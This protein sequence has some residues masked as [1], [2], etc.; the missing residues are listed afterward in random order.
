MIKIII[1]FFIIFLLSFLPVLY[2]NSVLKFDPT[3]YANEWLRTVINSIILFFLLKY[4][5][6]YIDRQKIKNKNLG[7]LEYYKQILERIKYEIMNFNSSESN[8]DLCLILWT[9]FLNLKS[10]YLEIEKS[11]LKKN[12]KIEFNLLIYNI[13]K[14]EKFNNILKGFKNNTLTPSEIEE[15]LVILNSII[16]EIDKL[17]NKL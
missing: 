7:F 13:D 11:I 16:S 1:S 17:K 4:L 15:A 6:S 3:V 12:H 9:K 8:S 14:I 5:I 2:Y 10:D